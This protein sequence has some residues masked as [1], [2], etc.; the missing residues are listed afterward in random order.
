MNCFFWLQAQCHLAAANHLKS[1]L[2]DGFLAAKLG[3]AYSPVSVSVLQLIYQPLY[4]LGFSS[5]CLLDV[6]LLLRE[7]IWIGKKIVIDF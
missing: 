3:V 1:F 4:L 2:V 5:F 7:I 6:I